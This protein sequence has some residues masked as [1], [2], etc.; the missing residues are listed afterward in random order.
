MTS[1]LH[2]L[3][4]AQGIAQ[5]R[6]VVVQSKSSGV[7][8][9]QISDN[10]VPEELKRLGQARDALAQELQGLLR[11]MPRDVPAELAA[12]IDVHLQLLQ[13]EALQDAVTVWITQHHYNAEWALT[14]QM[15]LFARQFDAMSDAYLRERKGDL[16]QVVDRLLHHLGGLPLTSMARPGSNDD[17][18]RIL[19]AHD[20]SPADMLRYREGAFAGFVTD[21]GAATSHTA[22]VARSMG[23]PAVVA[24]RGASELVPPDAWIILDGDAGLVLIDPPAQVRAQY[25]ARQLE[26]ARH[27]EGLKYLAVVPASTRDGQAVQLLANIE[28]PQDVAA[29]MHAGAAGVG[30]FRTEFLFM[31]RGSDLPGEEEQYA[32][33]RAVVEGMKGLPV[34][35]R[36]ID[37]GADKPLDGIRPGVNPALGLRAIRWSLS[38]LPMFRTQLR[39]LLRAAVHGPVGV[40]FPMMGN[41]DEARQACAQVDLARDELAAQGMLAGTVRLGAMVEVPAAALLVED[42]LQQFDFLSIGTNDLIQYTLAIDRSDETVAHLYDPLHPAVLRLIA[43]VLTAGEQ[44]GKEVSLCGEMAG[45]ASLTRLLLGMGLRHFSMQPT[46]IPRVKQQILQSD[47]AGLKAWADQVVRSPT[48]RSVWN[49]GSPKLHN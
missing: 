49:S 17:A 46:S 1:Y 47:A 27:A 31:G 45:D 43:M 9:R 2:G 4:V 34:T 28:S 48:P 16:H 18:P 10:E 11:T 5:G 36:T 26:L 40:L 32:A 14:T 8:R 38:D 12:M 3:A 7:P 41:L 24:A 42:F 33:Y 23:I 13:D 39:A 21:V 44:C 6:A 19:V 29:A 15:D 37:V 35:I 25:Q 30:L 22:I 20:L